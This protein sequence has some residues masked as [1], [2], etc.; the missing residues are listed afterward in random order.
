MS[1]STFLGGGAKPIVRI[2][3]SGWWLIFQLNKSKKPKQKKVVHTTLCTTWARTTTQKITRFF[4]ELG[5]DLVFSVGIR[6]VF[7]GFYQTNTG[8]KLGRYI[9]VLLSWREP[10]FSSKGGSRPPFWGAQPPFWGKKG[11]LPNLQEFPPNSLVL[12]IPTEIPTDQHQY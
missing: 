3:K 8:E 7:L 12:K 5:T 6:L 10:L 11:F 2:L 4:V 1:C 9:S